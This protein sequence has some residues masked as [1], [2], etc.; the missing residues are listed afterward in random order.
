MKLEAQWTRLPGRPDLLPETRDR[1]S[2]YPFLF[3]F[4]S[5]THTHTCTHDQSK[6]TVK[7]GLPNV[8]I[9][10]LLSFIADEMNV[11]LLP[12][13]SSPLLAFLLFSGL[14]GTSITLWWMT[15]R[16]LSVLTTLAVQCQRFIPRLKTQGRVIC[17][18]RA[19]LISAGPIKKA[20]LKRLFTGMLQ[21]PCSGCLSMARA[22][23][24]SRDVYCFMRPMLCWK[25]SAERIYIGLKDIK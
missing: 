11:S 23:T 13:P 15:P 5:L 6:E 14:L 8:L 22:C 21:C 1:K 4:L 25:V 7:D 2:N 10:C 9:L 12:L 18:N 20:L 24:L 19:L 16:I 3:L 17:F